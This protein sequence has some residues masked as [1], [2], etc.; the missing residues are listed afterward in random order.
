MT[1]EL[2]PIEKADQKI[3]LKYQGGSSEAVYGLG[4]IGAWA[5]YFTRATTIQQGVM[6]F[7]KGLFWPAFMVYEVLKLLEKE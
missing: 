2:N 7:F 4:L 5:Y 6:G 1:T 3:Q